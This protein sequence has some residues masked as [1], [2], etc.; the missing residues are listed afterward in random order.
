[1]S[2]SSPRCGVRRRIATGLLCLPLAFSLSGCG[3]LMFA[4][5]NGQDSGKLDPNV[6]L[7]D[8][9]G[10]LFF[11]LPGVVAYAVDF[12]TGA[13]YLPPGVEKGEGPFWRD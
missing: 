11:I 1:M 13:I 6:V 9:I 2:N 10:L 4:E 5:R 12:A 7:L 8:G 3:S